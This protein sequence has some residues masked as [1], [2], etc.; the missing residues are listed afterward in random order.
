MKIRIATL[1]LLL[2]TFAAFAATPNQNYAGTWVLDLD[3][4]KDMPERMREGTRSWRLDIAQ[5]PET[6]TIA[7]RIERADDEPFTDTH[8]HRLDG[9]PSTFDATMRTPDGPVK[10]PTTTTAKFDAN[11][12]LDLAISSEMQR[13]EMM[14]KRDTK[15]HL[16]L[17]PDG[18]TLSVH[19]LDQTRRGPSEYT[20]V[21]KRAA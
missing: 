1:S 17:S 20:M 13:G 10:V 11:G 2:L 15:E 18:K 8:T 7:I 16:S 9:Q 3:A 6:L 4:S 21:F 14:M 12:E 5:T 19:R